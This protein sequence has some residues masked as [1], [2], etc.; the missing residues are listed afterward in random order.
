[1]AAPRQRP[2][3]ITLSNRA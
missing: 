1:I 2:S 3:I